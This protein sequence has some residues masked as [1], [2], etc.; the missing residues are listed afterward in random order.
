MSDGEVHGLSLRSR[1]LIAATC[2][3]VQILAI[4]LASAVWRLTAGSWGTGAWI[5]YAIGLCVVAPLVGMVAGEKIAQWRAGTRR[6]WTTVLLLALCNGVFLLGAHGFEEAGVPMV[7][8]VS[9]YGLLLLVVL[10][11]ITGGPSATRSDRP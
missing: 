1:L 4:L 9:G 10:T 6:L 2:A 11:G 3:L 8:Y 5:V 7:T